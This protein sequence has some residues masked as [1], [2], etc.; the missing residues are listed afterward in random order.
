MRNERVRGLDSNYF[1]NNH[2][3]GNTIT[4]M[5]LLSQIGMR[6]KP[7]IYADFLVLVGIMISIVTKNYL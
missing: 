5:G 1:Y 4:A 6:K 2:A 3:G 7:T